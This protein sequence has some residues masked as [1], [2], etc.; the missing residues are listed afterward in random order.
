M[1]N[2]YY[3]INGFQLENSDSKNILFNNLK[4]IEKTNNIKHLNW[5]N[6]SDIKSLLEVWKN[7]II[8]DYYQYDN[9]IIIAKST[10][11]NLALQLKQLLFPNYFV[12]LVLINP[13]FDINQSTNNEL[14]NIK[15]FIYDFKA[16][17]IKETFIIWSDKD[18]VLNHKNYVNSQFI[19]DNNFIII[20]K[21][22]KHNIQK[23]DNYLDLIIDKYIDII[24]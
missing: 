15:N 14:H 9:I 4:N 8:A 5:N 13:L 6:K 12:K 2:K 23:I 19:N 20:D 3:Y 17:E 24:N 16:N 21:F 11:C 1:N 10:G 22:Q 18:E 7:E